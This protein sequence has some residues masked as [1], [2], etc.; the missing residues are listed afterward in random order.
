MRTLVINADIQ[1]TRPIVVASYVRSRVGPASMGPHP[2]RRG[3]ASFPTSAS[4]CT[5][6]FN[7]ATLN[8]AWKPATTLRTTLPA[9][10]FNGATLNQAWKQECP[11]VSGAPS[12]CFNGASLNQAWKLQL[13]TSTRNSLCRFNGATLN[14]AWK[15]GKC[16]PLH[17]CREGASMGPRSIRRGNPA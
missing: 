14:Q 11:W 15:R 5:S 1:I 4:F 2:I 6:C 12:R 9:R 16:R 10:C 7:E 13:A 17:S 3:N 8:Q